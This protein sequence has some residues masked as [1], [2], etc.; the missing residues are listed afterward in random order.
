MKQSIP[1]VRDSEDAGLQSVACLS[2]CVIS[3]T[4]I[5]QI[6]ST[7]VKQVEKKQKNHRTKTIERN[8]KI[9]F[10]AWNIKKTRLWQR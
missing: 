3:Q 5:L 2:A 10:A 1:S 6:T 9:I 8:E 7:S 4:G